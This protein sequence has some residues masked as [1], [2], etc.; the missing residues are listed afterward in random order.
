MLN[1]EDYIRARRKIESV[2]MGVQKE[3]LGTTVVPEIKPAPTKPT[4]P[5]KPSRN[6]WKRPSTPI[7]EPAPKAYDNNSK[8]EAIR[9]SDDVRERMDPGIQRAIESGENPFSKNPA[10]KGN[11]ADGRSI[12]EDL[13]QERFE[14]LV[15]SIKTRTGLTRISRAQIAQGIMNKLMM[16]MQ[17]EAGSERELEEMA[18]RVVRE[19]FGIAEDALQFEINLVPQPMTKPRAMKWDMEEEDQKALDELVDDLENLDLSKAKRRMFNAMTQG[20]A[21]NANHLHQMIADELNAIHPELADAYSILMDMN[22]LQY[23]MYDEKTLKGASE[24]EGGHFGQ[25]MVDFTTQPPTVHASGM[26]FPVLIHEAVKGVMEYLASYGIPKDKR[27]A[28][29]VIGSQDTLRSEAWDQKL[30]AA[31][32]NKFLDALNATGNGKILSAVVSNLAELDN[33]EALSLIRGVI[34]GGPDAR[35]A[36]G[37]F[38]EQLKQDLDAENDAVVDDALEDWEED[39]D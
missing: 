25:T 10:M 7:V 12:V 24:A 28:E 38:V 34:E 17:E 21:S 2:T 8:T 29:F 35:E 22:E 16:V 5:V 4:T 37:N 39:Q 23:W 11:K 9:Y 32:W 3:K 27:E 14:E 6:P 31:V 18:E 33:L 15:R 26:I 20:A 19:F 36:F 30:G 1:F 13:A